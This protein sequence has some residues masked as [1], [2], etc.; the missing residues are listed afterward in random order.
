MEYSTFTA[1]RFIMAYMEVQFTGTTDETNS[2]LIA[3]LDE[4]DYE[5]FEEEPGT[6]KAFI[7]QHI[8]RIKIIEDIANRF[9]LQHSIKELADT[10]WNNMW[11]SNFQPVEVDD[12]CGIRAGFH[13]PFKKV[14]HEIII[15]PK[16]SFGTGHHAT[17]FMMIHQ[18]K[19]IDFDGKK[20]MDFGTG[21]GVL[22]IL[23]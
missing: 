21:T 20:V 2:I 10:N 16:M 23:A 8:F 15:T 17:T 3:I 18:M 4:S 11:E 22:A 12:F 14:R 7:P 13:Q 19:D 1:E 5:G 6:L 9:Q